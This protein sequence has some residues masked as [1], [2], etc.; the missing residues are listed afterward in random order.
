MEEGSSELVIYDS[1]CIKMSTPQTSL[2]RE[3][4]ES[5]DN[6]QIGSQS[7][8]SS[9]NSNHTAESSTSNVSTQLP[10]K[11]NKIPTT[12]RHFRYQ[13]LTL[14]SLKDFKLRLAARL[15]E[16]VL[17]SE[18]MIIKFPSLNSFREKYVIPLPRKF[19]CSRNLDLSCLVGDDMF[20]KGFESSYDSIFV[21]GCHI[22]R[23]P[24]AAGI[25]AIPETK[26]RIM[27]RRLIKDL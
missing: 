12:N 23:I 2:V 5:S 18:L 25:T 11:K 9:E 13:P 8:T 22:P 17:E 16:A 26:Q 10:N 14:I 15:S 3:M 4:E 20:R 7:M 24:R 1:Q 21:K 6:A 19:P 27:Y